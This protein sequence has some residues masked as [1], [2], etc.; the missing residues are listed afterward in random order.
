MAGRSSFSAMSMRIS[1]R[2]FETLETHTSEVDTHPYTSPPEVVF[3]F[4]TRLGT[5]GAAVGCTGRYG[6]V[7]WGSIC[8]SVLRT[9]S[10]HS[11]HQSKMSMKYL[12]VKVRN[13][14]CL[15]G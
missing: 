8:I 9:F 12:F 7:E 4:L 10:F 1:G 14:V 5:G 2:V 3:E 11:L 13:H 15:R 6:G